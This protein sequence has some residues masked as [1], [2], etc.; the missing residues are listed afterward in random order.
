MSMP[1]QYLGD[2][3]SKFSINNYTMTFLKHNENL[4][5]KV[6]DSLTGK[7]YL[8]RIHRPFTSNFTGPQHTL[9]GLQSELQLLIHIKEKTSLVVQTPIRSNSSDFIIEAGYEGDTIMHFIW[10]TK[11]YTHG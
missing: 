2:I 4:T 3:M 10:K 7:A 6:I 1:D 8:L 11:R 5:Y 9:E